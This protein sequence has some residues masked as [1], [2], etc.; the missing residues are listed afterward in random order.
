MCFLSYKKYL[1]PL[2]TDLG[3]NELYL[4]IYT[5][6]LR[7]PSRGQKYGALPI[8]IN[9]MITYSL[10]GKFLPFKTPLGPN[11]NRQIPEEN[12][13]DL[14]MLFSYLD[15]HKT[16]MGLMVDLTN[17]NRFYD[18]QIVETKGAKHF[19]LQCRG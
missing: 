3:L 6:C 19:K 11:Y 15:G 18:K 14:Q 2:I 9:V 12:R 4:G 5:L 1:D 17:T 8:V 10:P 16:K 13:F 7:A